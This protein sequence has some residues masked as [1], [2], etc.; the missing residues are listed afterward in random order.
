MQQQPMRVLTHQQ[1]SPEAEQLAAMYQL[2]TPQ[3]EYRVRLKRSEIIYG[4]LAFVVGAIFLLAAFAGDDSSTLIIFLVL[5]LAFVAMGLAVILTP[6]FRHSWR[7]YV[8]S[9]GFAFV[10]GGRVDAFRWDQIEAMWQAITRRYSY[11]VY[12]GATHKYTVR[13]KDGV[14]VVFNDRFAQVEDLGNALSRAITDVVFPQVLAAYNAG[15]T[16]TFGSLSI[17]LQGVSN[18]RET[19]PWNQIKEIGV[20]R[21]VISVRREGKWLSWST[22]YASRVP[23]LFVF[24]ALVNYVLK[25]RQ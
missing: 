20:N 13:R 2:G 17:G 14:Q 10:R 3:S 6:I 16:I 18:G 8:C 7:V 15:Q 12:V 4:I 21:G 5:A 19:L 1:A 22:I 25:N 9:D 24:L 11:G 23:N